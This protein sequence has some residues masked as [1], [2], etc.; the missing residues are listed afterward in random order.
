MCGYKY[1]ASDIQLLPIANLNVQVYFNL[2][3]GMLRRKPSD[4]LC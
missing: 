2:K 4:I 3:R 1:D